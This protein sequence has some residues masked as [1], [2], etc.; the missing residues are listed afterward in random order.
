MKDQIVDTWPYP[1]RRYPKPDN[2]DYL[3]SKGLSS[4]LQKAI[5]QELT[6]KRDLNILDVGCGQK[7]FYPFFQ[8]FVKAYVGTDI[9]ADNPL[10]DI[11]C[12]AEHLEVEDQ[13]ADVVLC[14]A[15]LEHVDDPA[16]CVR[17]FRRVVKPGGV[18]FALT[19]GCF[20]W[21][22]YPQD[23]WRWTQT[24][25]QLLFQQGGFTDVHIFA[26]LGS[27]AGAILPIGYYIYEWASQT[28]FKRLLRRPL[29][30]WFNQVGERLDKKTPQLHD[31][32][33][34]VTFL[35]ELFVIAKL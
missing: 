28:R 30:T 31:V 16:Q 7:P 32:N 26:P 29:M 21:H 18:I 34:H 8:P 20:P 27:V 1:E 33:R 9:L 22:P 4:G 35:P 14:L 6:G 25:L 19:H 3:G 15:V 12:P 13:W 2:P 17:E 10:V 5:A 24:G 11:V 23:H